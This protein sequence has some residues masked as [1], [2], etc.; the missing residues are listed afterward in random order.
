MI[1]VPSGRLTVADT[2][3][4]GHSLL[5]RAKVPQKRRS[6]MRSRVSCWI[7]PRGVLNAESGAVFRARLAEDGDAAYERLCHRMGMENKE[8]RASLSR[9]PTAA[10]ATCTCCPSCIKREAHKSVYLIDEPS[11]TSTRS[12]RRCRIRLFLD[13]S[14][15][16]E[17]RQL[18]L[19]RMNSP[20]V[21][22]LRRDEI[23]LVERTRSIGHAHEAHGLP[24][25]RHLIGQR[26]AAA[27]SHLAAFRVCRRRWRAERC[28]RNLRAGS[29]ALS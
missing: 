9:N 20:P 1:F 10:S 3:I 29:G 21:D 8:F 18:I 28:R 7:T 24:Q 25:V 16:D 12:S 23:W 15:P 4:S 2:G 5:L 22:L 11:K 17:K 26:P 27:S 6:S 14:G 13:A 19:R